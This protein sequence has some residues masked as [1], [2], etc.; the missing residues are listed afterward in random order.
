MITLPR[1]D[2][3]CPAVD[4]IPDFMNTYAAA[5]NL[6]VARQLRQET[7]MTLTWI[8]K[9]LNMGASGSVAN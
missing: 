3:L 5:Q 7:T 6:K 1:F 8:A 4:L 9:S 2:N